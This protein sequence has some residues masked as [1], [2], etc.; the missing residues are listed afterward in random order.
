MKIRL[1]QNNP[2]GYRLDISDPT[3]KPLYE[4]Y[5]RWKRIP[6]WCPLTDEERHEFEAYIL[7]RE[8]GK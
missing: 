1:L 8:E 4:R 3:I 7:D 2:Y 6:P 5:K